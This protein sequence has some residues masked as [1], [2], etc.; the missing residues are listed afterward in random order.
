MALTNYFTQSLVYAL[1]LFGVGPGLGLAGRIG[2]IEVFAI[3][4]AAYAA[5]IALSKAWLARFRYGPLEWLWRRLTY[6]TAW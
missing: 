3:V 2:T 6:G 5:Q 1:V 4:T